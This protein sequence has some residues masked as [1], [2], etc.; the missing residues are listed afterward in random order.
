M[1]FNTKIKL[2]GMYLLGTLRLSVCWYPAYMLFIQNN[3]CNRVRWAIVQILSQDLPLEII[4]CL[5]WSMSTI[6]SIIVNSK[7]LVSAVTCVTLGSRTY[8]HRLMQLDIHILA[9]ST[10]NQMY[11]MIIVVLPQSLLRKIAL[12]HSWTQ[13]SRFDQRRQPVNTKLL[14]SSDFNPSKNS[15]N[16]V[17]TRSTDLFTLRG[18]PPKSLEQNRYLPGVP[19]NSHI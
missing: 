12:A 10:K 11:A 7:D 8:I 19:A 13:Q 4:G 1:L 15:E 17:L 6:H 18:I 2:K 3:A 16:A 9:I 5:G 14:Q